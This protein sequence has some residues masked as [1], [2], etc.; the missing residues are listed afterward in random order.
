MAHA[1]KYAR[2]SG[3]I[4]KNSPNAMEFTSQE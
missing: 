3:I 2:I 1:E 4:Q